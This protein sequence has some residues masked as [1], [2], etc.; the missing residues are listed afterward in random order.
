MLSDELKVTLTADT[1]KTM[2]SGQLG[3]RLQEATPDTVDRA[4][5]DLKELAKRETSGDKDEL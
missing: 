2:M 5:D 1:V 3:T 4:L